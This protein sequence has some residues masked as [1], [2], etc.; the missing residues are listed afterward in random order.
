M[1]TWTRARTASTPPYVRQRLPIAGRSYTV[2]FVLTAD[3][4]VG[5]GFVTDFGDLAPV[6]AV[7]DST[8]DHR[9]LNEVLPVVPTSENLAVW[10][11]GWFVEHV[12]PDLP[13]R[14]AAVRVSETASSWAEFQVA[15]R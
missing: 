13:G 3:Q 7:I 4:L 6:K 10:F 9:V 14:L 1:I 2:E 12:E 15:E 11:A 8:L 5:P